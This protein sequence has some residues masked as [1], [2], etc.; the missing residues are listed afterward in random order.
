MRNIYH[1]AR[2][3]IPTDVP[4]AVVAAAESRLLIAF[5]GFTRAEAF[6]AWL[7]A[8]N[9]APVAEPVYVYD[10]ACAAFMPEVSASGIVAHEAE[11]AFMGAS[12]I[13]ASIAREICQRGAQACVYLRHPTGE[14]QLISLQGTADAAGPVYRHSAEYWRLRS[15][16]G[17]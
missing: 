6:G 12:V 16:R 8:V 10:I 2:I 17:Y 9:A 4:P 15:A 7:P 3:I 5:G 11:R 13:L 1:E 14:V